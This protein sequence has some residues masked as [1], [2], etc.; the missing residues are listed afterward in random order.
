M[1]QLKH[2]TLLDIYTILFC[3]RLSAPDI[4]E[5]LCKAYIQ[6]VGVP[7]YDIVDSDSE[8]EE[9]NF[10]KEISSEGSP[11]FTQFCYK[12]ERF[13]NWELFSIKQDCDTVFAG[14]QNAVDKLK[15]HT[16]AH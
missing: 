10:Y 14:V 4:Y 9:R 2:N 11:S 5:H 7:F 3:T 6:K 15:E 8:D 1:E 12:Y 13:F 16:C